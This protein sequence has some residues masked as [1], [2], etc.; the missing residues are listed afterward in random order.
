MY[1]THF[2]VIFRH[3]IKDTKNIVIIIVIV[4]T[5][6]DIIIWIVF[7]LYKGQSV[8]RVTRVLRPLIIVNFSE[9]RNL[10]K[11]IRNIK[12]TVMDAARYTVKVPYFAT[13][14]Q[15]FPCTESYATYIRLIVHGSE[16]YRSCFENWWVPRA[17]H[18]IWL[19][20]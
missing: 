19:S 8:L 9:N 2:F 5:F 11:L 4:L 14:S 6:L 18:G 10:R 3:F 20:W 12:R 13:F 1:K 16:H 17:S 7:K 15:F